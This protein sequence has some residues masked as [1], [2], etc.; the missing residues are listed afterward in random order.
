MQAALHWMSAEP[1]YD[2]EGSGFLYLPQAAILH[3]PFALLGHPL[4]SIV[5][6]GVT[7][8]VFAFGLSRLCQFSRHRNPA[9]VFFLATLIALPNCVSA[10]RNGQ[11]T[12]L[13]TG[14]MML[15]VHGLAHA[16]WNFCAVCLSAAIAFK[17]SVA[18][19]LL[20]VAALH[21][22]LW[23]RLLL[24]GMIVGAF[25]YLTQH[26]SY[27]TEQYQA[28]A[29]SFI[30][31]IDH[32]KSHPFAHMFGMFEAFGWS[33]ARP[34]QSVV[35][36]VMGMLTLLVVWSC[37]RRL[38]V[39]RYAVYAFTISV[40]YLLLFNPRTENNTYAM[41]APAMG[42]FFAESVVARHLARRAVILGAIA[43]GMLMSY[44]AA[45]RIA[46]GVYPIWLSTLMGCCFMAVLGKVL[47]DEFRVPENVAP[48]EQ[49]E[50]VARSPQR[51]P[52]T[53]R[54][55]HEPYSLETPAIVHTNP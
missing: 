45:V 23:G 15:T 43:V 22:P 55:P 37:Q 36:A 7:I 8:G 40:G 26:R 4:G 51:S 13:L 31:T 19:F 17:P 18:P 3:V 48:E 49:L 38:P 41:L 2:G 14:L 30:V 44:E 24:G 50:F 1:L 34:I 25:P 20:T 9:Q 32:H 10:A 5:W 29:N 27:V 11:T 39:A 47:L 42:L 16:R 53:A 12:L 54:R 33:V 52:L 46:P 6:R 21:R 35:S 28:F